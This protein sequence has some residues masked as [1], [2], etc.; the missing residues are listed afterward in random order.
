MP[1]QNVKKEDKA[2]TEYKAVVKGKLK[3][4]GHSIKKKRL[5]K[6]G[7]AFNEI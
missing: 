7:Y 2:S 3:L 4:K 6:D 5:E 1:A